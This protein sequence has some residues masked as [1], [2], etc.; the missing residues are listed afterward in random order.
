MDE[1]TAAE[2]RALRARAFG[3]E[4]DIADD[5]SALQR[6]Q[7]LEAAARASEP[8]PEPPAPTIA[9]ADVPDETADRA[10]E[11]AASAPAMEPG[12]APPEVRDALDAE[13]EAPRGLTVAA[14]RFVSRLTPRRVVALWIASLAVAVIV[15][16]TTSWAVTRR[17]QADPLQVASLGAIAGAPLPAF[18]SGAQ[19]IESTVHADFHGLSA[20]AITSGGWMQQGA[21]DV[22]LYV[23]PT[24]AISSDSESLGGPVYYGCG[25][26]PFPAS[27][28]F[29][30]TEEAP[31][32]LREAFP[33]GSVLQFALQ[34]NEVVVLAVPA[35]A[36]AS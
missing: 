26:S 12:H 17:V 19:D 35:A 7:E 1:Q 30:V 22:C 25:A 27:V 24:V 14:R 11:A 15:A 5:S 2:L 9:A 32:E 4:A 21:N 31:A 18:L 10:V 13:P 3:P 6:L 16:A 28:E 33:V 20:V 29:S 23:V 34:G 36:P 8:A